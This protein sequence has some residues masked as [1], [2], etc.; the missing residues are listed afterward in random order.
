MIKTA[1]YMRV[2]TDHQAKEGDS[3]PAQKAALEQYI[4]ERPDMACVG[5]YMDGGVSGSKYDRDDLQRLLDDVRHGKIDTILFTK[6]DRWFRSMRHYIATQEILDQY[7]VTW[8]AIWEPIYDTTT[9]AGR[10]IVNQMMSIAQF[11]A[12]NTSQRIRAV[13]DYKIAQGEAITG[14]QPPGFKVVN[15]RVVPDDNADKVRRLFDHFAL[16]GKL[17]ETTRLAV[18][19]GFPYCRKQMKSMLR[20]TKYIGEYK[21]NTNYCPPIIDRDVFDRVQANLSMIVK[22]NVR[23]DYIFSGI[24]VCPKCGKRMMG[25]ALYQYGLTDRRDPGKG[26]HIKKVAK[27]YSCYNPA[28]LGKKIKFREAAIERFLL[29]NLKDI[30]LSYEIRE[31]PKDNRK[32]IAEL[33]KRV[34]RLK[35]LFVN[36]HISLDEYTKDK[37]VMEMKMAELK[38]DQPKDMSK[39]KEMLSGTFG[40][41]Y[42]TM[43]DEEKRFMW[44]SVVR[45][46]R[47]SREKPYSRAIQCDVEFA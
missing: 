3:I 44:R 47:P 17:C 28:C 18:E 20:N 10:L 33:D 25:L 38:Q 37:Q 21:G 43:T 8:S 42:E 39:V 24:M 26:M 35:T 30:V 14:I 5:V 9:P 32:K 12:E 45:E 7:G 46:I 40:E 36:G 15:K 6:L 41:L 29:S 4:T 22:S 13:F 16:T 11:E 31:K 19:L 27:G 34:E 2:S 1:L 23:R